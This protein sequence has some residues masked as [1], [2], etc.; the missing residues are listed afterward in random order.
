MKN[1]RLG[2]A[3]VIAVIVSVTAT[4]LLYSYAVWSGNC[5]GNS[6]R[7]LRDLV[8][9]INEESSAR[10]CSCNSGHHVGYSDVL[11]IFPHQ[12]AIRIERA[13][14]QDCGRLPSVGTGNATLG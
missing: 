13:A 1:R 10:S 3:L 7:V 5:G 9:V 12:A 6:V 2:L 8:E 4:F 11:S 14:N